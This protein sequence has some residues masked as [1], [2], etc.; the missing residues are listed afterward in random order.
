MMQG[1]AG[2]DAQV[3]IVGGGPV[4]MGL[5]IELGQRGIRCAVVERYR[6][7]QPI[8]KGQNL[9]QRT[10]EH[11]HF[12]HAEAAL[13][14]ARTIP[15]E[16]GI[17]GLTAYGTLLGGHAYDWLQRELV[18]PFYFTDNERL[19]QYATEAVLRARAAE[20]PAVATHYGWSATEIA[21][22]G[23][24][25][26]LTMAERDGTGRRQLRA[27]Y[28]VGCDGS[29][30]LVRE[31]AGITQT[32][33]DHDR[34]MVLLVFRSRGLHELL[35][36]FP[37]KSFYN[38]L[39]PDLDG[40]WQFF[41]RVDLGTTWFFHAPVPPGTTKDSMD[42]A[43]Y[44][45]RAVGAEFDVEFEHIGF[46]DLRVAIADGYRAGRVFIA[47][48]AA[49]SHPPYG[50][51]GINT[52]LEDA[53]NLGWK[54]AATL[55]GWGGAGLLDS[56]DA[57]R[58]PVFASTARDFIERSIQADRDFLRRFD[59]ARDP[60]AFE[61]EWRA[62][63]SGARSEVGAFE[64]HYEGSP[65]V[66]GPPGG[67]SGALGAHRFEARA[68][69]HL[70]PQPLAAGGNV[71]DAL[72][73]GFT[74]LALGGDPALPDR[75]AAAAARL[76]I[77]LAI[78]RDAGTEARERYA[79]DLVL[80]RPDQFVAWSAHESLPEGDLAEAEAASILRR[81]AGLDG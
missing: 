11:F 43:A 81:S 48:D 38:V 71:Y 13:R 20:I 21:Q 58:R 40:Y 49:H 35:S 19:P 12:W 2:T 64:P 25:V 69:H 74:L 14:A 78:L 60:V 4:G 65:I 44:L 26:T 17:G 47:G 41:G 29:R 52:G 53:A 37:G 1:A 16:Y 63:G 62:R 45:H 28:L 70:A 7:P 51:Y 54:L 10:L 80:V 75:F 5:A 24:G 27:D 23:E 56:Y 30:S 57:E 77:P 34:L 15:R 9:T 61:A 46:W 67:R 79:A 31:Q 66:F 33:S 36:R 59:P 6:Q 72:G 3:A 22:D 50:G 39:H 8:P 18:R 32:R 76:G 42:F 73:E 55:Q 68:G